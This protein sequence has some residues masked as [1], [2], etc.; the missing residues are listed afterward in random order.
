MQKGSNFT[1]KSINIFQSS[2]PLR[3]VEITYISS[4]IWSYL[5]PN[6]AC[7]KKNNAENISEMLRDT[8]N[9]QILNIT[10]NLLC[11]STFWD[12]PQHLM[13][14]KNTTGQ[15]PA[16]IPH[17]QM[18]YCTQTAPQIL[19]ALQRHTARSAAIIECTT[20]CYSKTGFLWS[21]GS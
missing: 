10:L 16:R 13:K 5:L 6:P 7:W 4:C 8:L 3:S 19:P 14:H 9:I 2:I 15:G 17:A 1:T 12:L 11:R 20:T 18:W 21:N